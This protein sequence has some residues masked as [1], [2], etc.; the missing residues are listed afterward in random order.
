MVHN[1]MPTYTNDFISHHIRKMMYA[2]RLSSTIN[3]HYNTQYG[4]LSP[5]PNL[6]DSCL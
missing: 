6:H 5:N 2:H 3:L 4:L 1:T